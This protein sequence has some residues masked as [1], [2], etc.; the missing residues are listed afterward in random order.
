MDRSDCM[1]VSFPL[2]PSTADILSRL[3]NVGFVP[4]ADIRPD[5]TRLLG[6][7]A[8][9][10]GGPAAAAGD[11]AFLLVLFSLN[12]RSIC[13]RS[14]HIWATSPI[15]PISSRFVVQST[16]VLLAVGFLT[17]LGIVGMKACLLS[18]MLILILHTPAAAPLIVR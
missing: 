3:E 14:L 4:Q 15:M 9:I 5:V 16:I 17:L 7:K 11:L 10:Q 8:P 2:Y 18:L 12:R 6:P 13:M 1:P